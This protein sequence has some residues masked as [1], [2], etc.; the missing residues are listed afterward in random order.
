MATATS[1]PTINPVV[2]AAPSG[3][4]PL[5]ELSRA[6]R[7]YGQII[8]LNDV[9]C[10]IGPGLTA[11]LGPNGAGKSTFIKLITGQMRPTTG[12]VSVVGEAPFAN[13]RVLSR[14]GYCPEID[15]FY[16]EMSGREF[17]TQM[18][19]MSGYGGEERKRR[20]NGA[21]D[22]VGMADRC[23]RKIG[24]YSKGMRQ[25]IKVAQA[26][27]HEP[28]VLVLDEPLN[29]LDPLGRREMTELMLSFASEGRCVLI[30]SH[31]LHEVEQLTDNILLMQRGRLLAQ[32]SVTGIRDLMD[33]HPHHVSL[34]C[35]RAR[36]LAVELLALPSVLGA[37]IPPGE[38][39]KVVI[40]TASPDKFYNELP[41]VVLSGGYNLSEFASPDNSLETV[42]RYLLEG[43]A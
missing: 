34:S 36:E 5:I 19:A 37:R 27:L 3:L 41:A 32:G 28:D 40:E 8:G 13:A 38:T 33:R 10:R 1:E 15:N 18:A 11:L 26:I 25:R 6:S 9:S 22:R 43:M 42:M 4:A 24:G 31:I 35:D 23:D 14:L 20:V 21:I 7:W 39:N 12:T 17:V 30:S 16:E 2:L 29:G